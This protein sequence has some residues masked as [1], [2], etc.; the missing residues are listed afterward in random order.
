[1]TYQKAVKLLR[2]RFGEPKHPAYHV[3]QIRACRRKEKESLPE[4]AQWFKK[5]SLRAYPSERV[6]TRDRILLD[7]FVRSLPDESQRCYVW[8][9]T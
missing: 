9:G 8:D 1:M 6:D 3:A 5:I 4:L 7:F 2:E